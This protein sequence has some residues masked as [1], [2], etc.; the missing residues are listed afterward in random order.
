MTRG[1]H[2]EIFEKPV[3]TRLLDLL[4]ASGGNVSK[5]IEHRR[6]IVHLL[7]EG[8]AEALSAY[9]DSSAF[10]ATP[11]VRAHEQRYAA[12]T[13]LSYVLF[14]DPE[15]KSKLLDALRHRD[16]SE[17]IASEFLIKN[18][19]HLRKLSDASSRIAE[20]TGV[21]R[22]HILALLDVLERTA[23]AS[24]DNR[25]KNAEP[26]VALR[27]I[28][29]GGFSTMDNIIDAMNKCITEQMIHFDPYFMSYSTEER[30][31][32]VRDTLTVSFHRLQAVA[33]MKHE[34]SSSLLNSDVLSEWILIRRSDGQLVVTTKTLETFLSEKKA[35]PLYDRLE[36]R[37]REGDPDLKH[38]Q[39]CPI[40]ILPLFLHAARAMIERYT[41]KTT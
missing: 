22:E 6:H 41:E 14:R 33:G 9:F 3:R 35:S 23:E 8:S 2:T 31:K 32:I 36:R 20:D 13:A 28:M 5:A 27:G 12:I 7:T 19:T 26:Y 1:E 39:G 4:T 40:V 38:V 34:V 21:S 16:P 10:E 37:H 17:A 11:R 25:G 18:D 29:Y 30:R 15:R 24:I